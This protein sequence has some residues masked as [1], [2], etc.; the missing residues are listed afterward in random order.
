MGPRRIRPASLRRPASPRHA[1]SA[2]THA[3]SVPFLFAVLLS[4]GGTAFGQ[5]QIIPQNGPQNGRIKIRILQG[6]PSGSNGVEPADGAEEAPAAEEDADR[7]EP[8]PTRLEFARAALA[9]E[10][11]VDPLPQDGPLLLTYERATLP[12]IRDQRGPVRALAGVVRVMNVGNAPVH[13]GPG[14]T[15]T[16]GE[17]AL[18]PNDRPDGLRNYDADDFRG[19]LGDWEAYR[20]IAPGTVAEFPATFFNLAGGI[21]RLPSPLS[22]KV[23]YVVGGTPV[24][25]EAKV[26]GGEERVVE[27]EI[28]DY[29]RGLA[30]LRTRRT[31]PQ[32]ALAVLSVRGEITFLGR[33]AAV[34]RLRTL[35]NEGVRR[36]VMLFE[37]VARDDDGRWRPAV[38]PLPSP[39][40]D[41]AG[42]TGFNPAVESRFAELASYNTGGAPPTR[43]GYSDFARALGLDAATDEREPSD[44]VNAAALDQ[45]YRRAAL[46]A[47][48]MAV[49]SNGPV[50]D[51]GEY[52]E[53]PT[54]AVAEV[55]ETALQSLDPDAAEAL[56]RSAEPLVRPAAV[57]YAGAN[58]SPARVPLLIALTEDEADAVRHAAVAALGAFNE[59]A[60]RK[61]LA[62]L[63]TTADD[64]TLAAD[65]A[66]SLA[67]SRFPKGRAKLAATLADDAPS[68]P[69]EVFAVLAQHPDP[70][71]EDT[72]T[73]LVADESGDPGVRVAALRALVA[74]KSAAADALLADAIVEEQPEIAEAAFAVLRERAD[75]LS[76]RLSADYALGALNAAAENGDPVPENIDRFLEETRPAA[77]AEP[78]WT[79][80]EN[81]LED[82]ATI[83]ELLAAI[84]PEAGDPA[85]AAAVGGRLADAWDRLDH[86]GREAVMTA[87]AD[88]APARLPPLAADGLGSGNSSTEENSLHALMDTGIDDA[89]IDR[90]LI[91]AFAA[92]EDADAAKRLALQ[93]VTRASPATRSALLDRRWD[94]NDARRT[95]AKDAVDRL[96][97]YGPAQAFFNKAAKETLADDDKDNLPD[98]GSKPHEASLRYLDIALRLDPKLAA[99]WSQRAFSRGQA[100]QLEGA[101]DDYRRAL[102]LD[103][104]DNLALTGLAILEIELGGDVDGGLARAEAG[105][106]KYPD[107][108]LFAYNLACVYGVAA[109]EL[110]KALDEDD[111]DADEGETDEAETRERI[112]R[113]L[114]K[115]RE[116]LARSYRLGLDS[117]VHRHHA[118]QDPDLAL[119]HGDPLFEQ[120]VDGTLPVELNPDSGDGADGGDGQGAAAGEAEEAGVAV[121]GAADELREAVEKLNEE[122]VEMIL[123]R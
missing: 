70:A 115:A 3:R 64:P 121:E 40:R 15:L 52:Y 19:T 110:Q 56:I 114:D 74:G 54:E 53:D 66:A 57:R 122:A 69:A 28:N 106:E 31:G 9:A 5:L 117:P 60:A 94:E 89:V 46:I 101:R 25:G 8:L 39:P 38:P 62:R 6:D 97:Q 50:S 84:A 118:A 90:L 55:L 20:T 72:L 111:A 81:D 16:A 99:G 12:S 91:E 33:F 78:L 80:F 47:G 105:F 61:T 1:V 35:S 30:D 2:V 11:M 71:W 13:L 14:T 123:P 29:H 7:P 43:A 10:G 41:D 88:L 58:L 77:A 59:A 51:F 109:K 4:C 82:L 68:V 34:Q 36:G 18:R 98:G 32:N 27:L 96:T 102:E 67:S 44:D 120:V 103:P 100:G 75:S 42:R 65:A 21:D 49:S 112:E 119:L 37:N 63:V 24:P 104:Y 86:K 116:H 23:P 92:A 76:R 22:L 48:G 93:L 107:D 79:M 45:A 95:A 108:G 73:T 87:V 17:G 113:Y 83:V 85:S 26:E